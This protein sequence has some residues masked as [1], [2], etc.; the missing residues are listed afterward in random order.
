MSIYKEVIKFLFTW[1]CLAV[2]LLFVLMGLYKRQKLIDKKE[3]FL[4][5]RVEGTFFTNYFC[6]KCHLGVDATKEKCEHCGAELFQKTAFN[7]KGE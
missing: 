1:L 6:P 2:A 5:D 7:S 3:R 4:G